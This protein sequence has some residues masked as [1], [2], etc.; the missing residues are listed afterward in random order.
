MQMEMTTAE[1]QETFRAALSHPPMKLVL[2]ILIWLNLE[3][4]WKAAVLAG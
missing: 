2:E 3:R 1:E 4:R